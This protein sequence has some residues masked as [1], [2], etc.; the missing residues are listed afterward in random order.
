MPDPQHPA[1]DDYLSLARSLGDRLTVPQTLGGEHAFAN[2]VIRQM[3][4]DRLMSVSVPQAFGGAGLGF[5]EIVRITHQ[6]ALTSTSAGLIY[7]MHMSQSLSAVCHAGQTPFFAEF[8][9]RLASDQILIASGTTETGVGG[10]IFGS[11]CKV[12]DGPGGGLTLTK[13]TPIMSYLDAAGAVLV[14]AIRTLPGGKPTQVLVCVDKARMEI[15]PGRAMNLMGMRGIFNSGYH[16]AASFD[17][18]AIFPEDFAA[19][20]RDTMTPTINILW[21]AVWSAIAKGTLDKAK[22]FLAKD[23]SAAGPI[24]AVT[25][26]TL[27]EL[28]AK[29]HALNALI[30][31]AMA[32]YAT[33]AADLMAG[34]ARTAHQARLKVVA[35]ELLLEICY[36]AL[37]LIGMPAYS[38][39]GPYS[40][41]ELFAD[42][43]SAPLMVSNYRLTLRNA[44]LER[45]I[46][47]T[48]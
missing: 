36:G 19:I 7:A 14:T 20:Q 16:Y 2:D 44:E 37:G 29:H 35:S 24:T 40:L 17:E 28:I 48:L 8:Q 21:A 1:N 13:D 31:D 33:P 30:R 6:V 26:F 43:L 45:Y 22:A 41:A 5:D 25:Q 46:E 38:L 15:T 23:K 10:D 42:A 47:E 27:S 12:E 4:A 9:R 11:R 39:E 18:S 3:R 32:E 34:M